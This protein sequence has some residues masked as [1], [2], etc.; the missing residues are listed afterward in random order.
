MSEWAKEKGRLASTLSLIHGETRMTQQK[1]EEL[2]QSVHGLRQQ[3][4]SAFD[5]ALHI[6][7]FLLERA[8]QNLINLKL[9]AEKPYFCR[10][11]FRERNREDRKSV[12]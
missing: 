4:A 8:R 6:K 12:V 5:S 1:Y 2:S 3:A 9:A 11:D 10:V 7:T